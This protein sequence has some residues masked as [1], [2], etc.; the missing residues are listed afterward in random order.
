MIDFGMNPQT[1]LDAPRF[2]IGVSSKDAGSTTYL[3][4]GIS[5]SVVQELNARGHHVQVAKGAER[6]TFGRGQIIYQ[7]A[8]SKVLVGGSDPRGDGM[9]AGY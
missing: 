7:D 8:T 9:A 5:E 6:S 4:E 3:E 1:A 2:C